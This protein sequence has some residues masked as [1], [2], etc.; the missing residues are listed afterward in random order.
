MNYSRMDDYLGPLYAAD[1]DAGR[2][3]EEEAV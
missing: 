2:I 3:T 1:I